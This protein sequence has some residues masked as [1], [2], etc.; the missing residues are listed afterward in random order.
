MKYLLII[1]ILILSI[2]TICIAQD[3]NSRSVIFT[4]KLDRTTPSIL[5][6]NGAVQELQNMKRPAPGIQVG[7]ERRSGST[8]YDTGQVASDTI[9]GIFCYQNSDLEIERFYI[10]TN[11]DIYSSGE[12]IPP[13]AGNG[14]DIDFTS[15]YDLNSGTSPLHGERINDDMV[16]A[17]TGQTPFAYSGASA[18]PDGFLVKHEAGNTNYVDGYNKVRDNREDTWIV[19]PEDD[20]VVS[21]DSE[22]FYVG[23][24]R[25]LNGIQLKLNNYLTAS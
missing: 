7:W 16:W 2:A 11:D 4:E 12:T 25:R 1:L 17:G 10:Q 13:S 14:G 22:F 5:L 8:K 18:Y 24:R 9:S 19:M 15:I 23:Y 3:Y 6:N 20:T 21:G